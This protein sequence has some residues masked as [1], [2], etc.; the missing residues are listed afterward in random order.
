[1]IFLTFCQVRSMTPDVAVLTLDDVFV[2][3][4]RFAADVTS[5]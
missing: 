4:E 1:V 3:L 2:P 5:V